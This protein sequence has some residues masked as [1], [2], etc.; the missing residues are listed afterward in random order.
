[1]LCEIIIVGAAQADV[2]AIVGAGMFPQV[3]IMKLRKERTGEESEGPWSI[4]DKNI[5]LF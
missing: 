2:Q 5:A 1:M 3:P 4:G